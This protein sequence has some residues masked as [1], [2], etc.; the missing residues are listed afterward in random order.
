MNLGLIAS[1][2]II[3]FASNLILIMKKTLPEIAVYSPD[4][5]FAVRQMV[6][7]RMELFSDIQAV[8]IT[9][10]SGAIERAGTLLHMTQHLIIL[11]NG[12]DSEELKN[13]LIQ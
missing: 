13:L 9:L 6:A 11:P 8:G 1:Q 7:D 10:S 12:G 3:N 5:A 2:F 4:S